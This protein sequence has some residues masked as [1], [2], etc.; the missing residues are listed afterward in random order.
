MTGPEILQEYRQAGG[1]S[2]V[3]MLTGKDS[4]IDIESGFKA[5]ADDYLTK[6]F[7]ARE[8]TAR[9]G[10]LLRRGPSY[11]G[12]VLRVGT[13]EL[14]R[15]KYIVKRMGEEIQLLPKEFSLLE[16]LMRNQN[17]VFSSEMLL[18]KFGSTTQ[19]PQPMRLPVA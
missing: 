11:L 7:H 6:P 18:E 4:I 9:I 2:P 14:D 8:L 17:R 19:T 13:L 15:G 1:S 3:L 5:G 16:F 12:D 10:A